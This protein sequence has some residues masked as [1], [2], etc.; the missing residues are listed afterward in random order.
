[1]LD[2]VIGSNGDKL[3]SMIPHKQFAPLNEIVA[4]IEFFEASS[5]DIGGQTLYFGGV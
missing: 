2:Q 3:K 5:N 1:M 4:A